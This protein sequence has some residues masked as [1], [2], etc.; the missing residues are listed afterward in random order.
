MTYPKNTDEEI[1]CIALSWRTCSY[2]RARTTPSSKLTILWKLVMRDGSTLIPNHRRTAYE[3]YSCMLTGICG[4]EMYLASRMSSSIRT[5]HD[6]SNQSPVSNGLRDL[7]VVLLPCR[8]DRLIKCSGLGPQVNRLLW[9]GQLSHGSRWIADDVEMEN[10]RIS[11]RGELCTLTLSLPFCLLF[12][13][14]G[15]PLVTQP[16]HKFAQSK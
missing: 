14:F 4:K 6:L 13:S 7:Q 16:I 8:L 3:A 9:F 15:L 10:V 1:L 5:A 12:L 2:W 11:T